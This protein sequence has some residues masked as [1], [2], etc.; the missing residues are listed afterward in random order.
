MIMEEKNQC[1]PYFQAIK[2]NTV[3]T[4]SVSKL[5]F[6]IVKHFSLTKDTSKSG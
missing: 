1:I 6:K 2:Y 5:F 3:T 4:K